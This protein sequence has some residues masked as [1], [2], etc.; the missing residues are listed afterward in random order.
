MSSS[1]RQIPRYISRTRRVYRIH[2]SANYLS[3]DAKDRK[4]KLTLCGLRPRPFKD[5]QEPIIADHE[6]DVTC[7]SCLNLLDKYA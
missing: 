5:A 2:A 1:Q 7:K 4:I 3:M 6:S